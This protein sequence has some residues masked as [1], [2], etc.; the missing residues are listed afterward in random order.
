MRWR[1]AWESELTAQTRIQSLR[2]DL[3]QAPGPAGRGEGP[4]ATLPEV[5]R[6][7]ASWVTGRVPDP[8]SR[9][10]TLLTRLCR[11]HHQPK[12]GSGAISGCFETSPASTETQG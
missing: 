11:E 5:V 4:P 7:P 9:V 10:Q 2:M 12:S 6:A 1:S 8:S 3:N